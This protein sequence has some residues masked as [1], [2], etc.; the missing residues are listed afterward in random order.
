MHK[1]SDKESTVASPL[2][3]SSA[4]SGEHS[5]ISAEAKFEIDHDTHSRSDASSIHDDGP[6]EDD[7]PEN[8]LPRLQ[9]QSTEL[10][11]AVK[12]ARLK[13]RGLLGQLALVAEVENP[14]TYPRRMKWFITF[15]VALAGSTAP[16]GSAI[17]FRESSSLCSWVIANQSVSLTIPS[18]QRTEY[19]NYYCQSNDRAIYAGYGDLPFVVVFL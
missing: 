3:T 9:R 11:P 5:T 4:G 18:N 13:R 15:I 16:L 7:D 1:N 8:T 19:D 17:F 6:T 2:P 12:V 10:G 14:K